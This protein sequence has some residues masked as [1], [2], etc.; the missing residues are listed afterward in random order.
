[1][2]TSSSLLTETPP[3]APAGPLLFLGVGDAGV[4]LGRTLAA[5]VRDELTY[6]G[7][8]TD[9]LQP[10]GDV[11]IFG[12]KLTRGFGCGGDL[13][14]GRRAA[15]QDTAALRELVAGRKVVVIIAGLGGGT[16]TGA[17]PLVARL[18]REA[19][20]LVVALAMLP[21][22]FEAPLRNEN[23]KAGLAALKAAAD[24]T[25]C[26][27]N[28]AA[29]RELDP[30]ASAV[31][32]LAG[33][34]RLIVKTL[35]GLWRLLAR[36]GLIRVGPAELER[37]LRGLH[38]ETGFA[39]VEAAGEDRA[40]QA[41]E[42]LLAHPF[43]NAGRAVTEADAVLVSLA[44]GRL[45]MDELEWLQRQ[46]HE[47]CRQARLLVGTSEDPDLGDHLAITVVT[48]T[49]G[50]PP[51]AEPAPELEGRV[52]IPAELAEAPARGEAVRFDALNLDEPPAP[53]GAERAPGAAASEPKRGGRGRTVYARRKGEQQ[54]FNFEVTSRGRFEQSEGTF[55]EG[56]N[57]DEPTFL[58]RGLR[59][60]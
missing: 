41:L 19:G 3:V 26:L 55:Y 42:Q 57:L 23:A 49:Q 5:Q 37:L 58:R 60:N 17:A 31:A 54:T 14:Q 50:V 13:Q 52:I 11:R 20:A 25:L 46:L 59:L 21:F 16:G 47:H 9:A 8:N 48:A 33:A 28:D 32:V 2:N 36:P 15:E 53:R 56:Q 34:D 22:T 40:R 38:G 45:R 27:S 12:A 30:R 43:L 24:V 51:A 4:R 35:Q 18:A 44:G 6:V 39:T 29:A 7:L 10:A 1:M